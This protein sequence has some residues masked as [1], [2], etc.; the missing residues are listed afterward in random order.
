MKLVDRILRILIGCIVVYLFGFFCNH[1]PLWPAIIGVVLILSG[2]AGYC[3][4]YKLLDRPSSLS[5]KN[6]AIRSAVGLLWIVGFSI[7]G[8]LGMCSPWWALMVPCV[9][10]FWTLQCKKVNLVFIKAQK[11]RQP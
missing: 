1:L 5:K 9:L 10:H 6:R 2:A 7:A 8:S 4:A 3:P 11:L